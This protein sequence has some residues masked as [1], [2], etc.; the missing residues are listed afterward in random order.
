MHQQPAPLPDPPL[1]AAAQVRRGRALAPV[2]LLALAA[3]RP[4]GPLAA[5]ALHLASPALALL[6]F[7]G[8][9]GW[10]DAI[11]ALDDDSQS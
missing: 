4:L 11:T 6:G 9:E 3:H 2:A 1:P 8:V 7:E 10:A 5:T